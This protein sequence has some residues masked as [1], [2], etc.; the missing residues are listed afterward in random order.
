[1]L[2]LGKIGNAMTTPNSQDFKDRLRD[3]LRPFAEATQCGW[4]STDG[5]MQGKGVIDSTDHSIFHKAKSTLAS[6]EEHLQND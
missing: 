6:I 3:A 2:L 1:M 4:F 5:Y